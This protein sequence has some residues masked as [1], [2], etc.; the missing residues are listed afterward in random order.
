VKHVLQYTI[1]RSNQHLHYPASVGFTLK[2][3]GAINGQAVIG[4]Y[5]A[6]GLKVL[7]MQAENVNQELISEIAAGNLDEGIYV[8]QVVVNNVEVHSAKMVARK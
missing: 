1:A 3:N 5:N 2:L 7:E 8:V 4:M 6:S